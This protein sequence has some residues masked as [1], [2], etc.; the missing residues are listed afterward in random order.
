MTDNPAKAFLRQYLAISGRVSALQSAISR[1]MQRA[2]NTGCFLKE[3]VVQ[4]STR[5]DTM[6]ENIVKAV[7]ATRLLQE[8]I[9]EANKKLRQ[10]L[11]AIN[12]LKDERQKELLTRRYVTGQSFLKIEQEMHYSETR[13]FV[14]H[15]RALL[16]I[17]EWLRRANNESDFHV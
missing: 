17:N 8:Q 15:G 9:D 3:I 4:T 14:I 2:Q 7:D 12:S 5:G 11:D 13:V 10:I 1:E 6:A 16:G